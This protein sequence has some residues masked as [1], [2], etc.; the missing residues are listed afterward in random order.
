MDTG[1]VADVKATVVMLTTVC[2]WQMF[3][4][5]I[6]MSADVMPHIAVG[7]ATVADVCHM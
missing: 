3:C 2:M 4:H 7:M 6:L 1:V 5:W